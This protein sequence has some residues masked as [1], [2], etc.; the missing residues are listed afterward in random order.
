MVDPEA[1]ILMSLWMAEHEQ[2]LDDVVWSWTTENSSLL[3]IQRLRNMRESFPAEAK[4]RLAS[5]AASRTDQSNDPRWK[6][7]KAPKSRGFVARQSKVRAIPSRF[8]GWPTLTLQL[9]LGMGVGVKADVLAFVLGVGSVGPDWT[10]VATIA[11]AVSYTP[12]AVRRAADDLARARFIRT[13]DTDRRPSSHRMYSMQ[14]SEW[15]NLLRVSVHQPGWAYWTRHYLFVVDLLAWLDRS[16]AA[17]VKDYAKDVKARELL[18]RHGHA[19]QHDRIIDRREFESAEL[20]HE[21]LLS[22][23]RKLLSWL[24]NLG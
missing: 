8:D 14:A 18:T 11:D 21:F 3:S 9:R 16:S 10:N 23:A 24:E 7:L 19:L 17:S 2:R 1:L 13:L 6:S 5:L 4:T 22:T 15:A 12:A 20:N